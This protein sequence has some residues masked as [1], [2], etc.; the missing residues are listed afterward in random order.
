M[1]IKEKHQLRLSELI[2]NI[3]S[4]KREAYAITIRDG[5]A[6]R[7]D[8]NTDKVKRYCLDVFSTIIRGRTGLLNDLYKYMNDD[9]IYTYLKRALS[10]EIKIIKGEVKA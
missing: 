7:M 1:K 6:P 10:Y 2:Q 5:E 9:H 8:E 4:E 3:G